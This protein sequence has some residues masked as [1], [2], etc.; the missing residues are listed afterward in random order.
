MDAR[1][2]GCNHI[3]T[4]L[5]V[6]LYRREGHDLSVFFNLYCWTKKSLNSDAI[7]LETLLKNGLSDELPSGVSVDH[8]SIEV[9]GKF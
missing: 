1:W 8:H 5:F 3:T 6:L 4:S 9:R 2:I 7:E